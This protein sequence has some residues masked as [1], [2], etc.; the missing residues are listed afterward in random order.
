MT[1]DRVEEAL[2]DCAYCERVFR[3]MLGTDAVCVILRP[4]HSLNVVVKVAINFETGRKLLRRLLVVENVKPNPD[5]D[6]LLRVI[7]F[8]QNEWTS[9]YEHSSC[10]ARAHD[11][12]KDGAE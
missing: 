2:K 3:A 10:H 8:I 5:L 1:D 7:A 11:E 4:A 12:G 6:E 9:G